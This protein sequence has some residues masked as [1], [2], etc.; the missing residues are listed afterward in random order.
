MDMVQGPSLLVHAREMSLSFLIPMKLLIWKD[1]V[2]AALLA[3]KV[4]VALYLT[5]YSP[6]GIVRTV[7]ECGRVDRLR[8]DPME[9]KNFVAGAVT[10]IRVGIFGF[11][12]IVQLDFVICVYKEI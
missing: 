4:T 8:L 10:V 7:I 12:I 9:L 3:T 5:H 11:A 2:V 6:C 1:L